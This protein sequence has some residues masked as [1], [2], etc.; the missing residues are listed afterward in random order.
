MMKIFAVVFFV[1]LMFGACP[2]QNNS[3]ELEL[4]EK[5]LELKAKELELK[6]KAEEKE[7]ADKEVAKAEEAEKTAP[8]SKPA[9]TPK[10]K[11]KARGSKGCELRNQ[12]VFNK[13]S[14]AKTF[15]C[16][17]DTGT[18]NTRHRYLLKAE[19]GQDLT[20]SFNSTGASYN[21][22]APKGGGRANG[23]TSAREVI[24]LNEDGTWTVVVNINGGTSFSDYTVNFEIK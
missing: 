8:A 10:P 12:V 3:K 23:V 9:A 14:S 18:G 4:K 13:G 21:V 17:L 2:N 11:P 22:I 19:A 1:A 16:S 15:K 7:E 6:K 24:S 5:E 20:I